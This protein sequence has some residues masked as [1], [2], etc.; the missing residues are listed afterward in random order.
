MPGLSFLVSPQTEADAAATNKTFENAYNKQIESDQE[1]ARAQS[2]LDRQE[3]IQKGA[4]ARQQFLFA[5]QKD[6]EL[7]KEKA[8]ID[9]LSKQTSATDTRQF[10]LSA[11]T[12]AQQQLEDQMKPVMATRTA[13]LENKQ[14]RYDQSKATDAATQLGVAADSDRA[15]FNK[16]AGDYLAA[17][18]VGP[19]PFDFS[20]MST[21]KVMTSPINPLYVETGEAKLAKINSDI[22]NS[23]IRTQIALNKARQAPADVRKLIGNLGAKKALSQ[24]AQGQVDMYMH[25]NPTADPKND[26]RLRALQQNAQKM[27]AGLASVQGS[28]QDLRKTG[29]IPDD[30]DQALFGTD[31]DAGSS[32]QSQGGDQSSTTRFVVPQSNSTTSTPFSSP[33]QILGQGNG[34]FGLPQSPIPQFLSPQ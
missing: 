22:R 14:N 1:D 18:K 25:D 16:A 10:L 3:I 26:I 11:V 31:S 30:I 15:A 23:G 20:G 4:E 32:D 27:Q 24:Q 8:R 9:Y 13:L 5:Q 6:I 17:G 19:F 28:Y 29:N 7:E 2:A 33:E 34:G 21:N 12:H